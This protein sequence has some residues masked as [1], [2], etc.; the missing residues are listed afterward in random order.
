[1]LLPLDF[2]LPR[3][4]ASY[5]Y[6]R[7]YATEDEARC[8]AIDSQDA[9]LPWMALCSFAYS[10]LGTVQKE[11]WP[12]YMTK[13]H[14]VEWSWMTGLLESEVLDWN[15]KRAGAYVNLETCGDA[16]IR[17]LPRMRDDGIPLLFH[18]RLA[19]PP[20]FRNILTK[21]NAALYHNLKPT[22]R[23][24]LWARTAR[25]EAPS[26]S[27]TCRLSPSP[28]SGAL[29]VSGSSP[30]ELAV[31]RFRNGLREGETWLHFFHRRGE[32]NE[33]IRSME[34]PEE[35]QRREN[36]EANTQS[37]VA[38]GRK[39][40]FVYVWKATAGGQFV[41]EQVSRSMAETVFLRFSSSQRRYDG[42]RNE[43]DVCP[44]LDPHAI[45]DDDSDDGEPYPTLSAGV[46]L[47]DTDTRAEFL[48]D[49]LEMYGTGGGTAESDASDSSRTLVETFEG[50]AFYRYGYVWTGDVAYDFPD[51]LTTEVTDVDWTRIRNTLLD[52]I[53][54]CTERHKPHLRNF[55][56]MLKLRR[57]HA[58]LHDLHTDCP[59]PPLQFSASTVRVK[60]LLVRNGP[61]G[62]P[63]KTMYSVSHTDRNA[64]WI[65]LVADASTALECARHY[66]D[67][68]IF[69][70]ARYLLLRG[71]PFAT[72][73]KAGSS[74][75]SQ[76][77]SLKDALGR[78][79][80]VYTPNAADYAE[81]ETKR[82]AFLGQARG[83]AAQLKGGIIWRLSKHA[84]G[85]DKVLVGP[86]DEV[87]DNA[88]VF[89]VGSD[90]YVDD[91]LS[92]DEMDLI[93]GVYKVVTGSYRY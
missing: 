10:R 35:R 52:N 30:R 33:R 45:P 78:R 20:F 56:H 13:N 89:S 79:D 42:F 31:P 60:S 25:P 32:A 26:A 57:P 39:G 28:G 11:N 22:D 87:A 9:F 55:F 23:E 62:D 24:L 38:P 17:Y 2:C 66:F 77:S 70:V 64:T 18:W 16:W 84:V 82:D 5:G 88:R 47:A 74:F 76:H 65:L 27:S 49:A 15:A 53:S 7:A 21:D 48:D 58:A 36:R 71:S 14:G 59:N 46:E 85:H 34:T 44:W 19:D 91:D 43:W 8:R 86:S 3:P 81:Y 54:P 69:D 37:G 68:S 90:T 12:W 51:S 63:P 92:E 93:C 6:R 83:R 29:L 1:M 50:T 61:D 75:V 80:A 73:I 40:A 72:A 4:P 67:T 41:R